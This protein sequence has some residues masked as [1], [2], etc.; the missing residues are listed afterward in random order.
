MTE[1]VRS[2]RARNILLAA[3]LAGLSGGAGLTRAQTAAPVGHN[4][5]PPVG[6]VPAPPNGPVA[7][8]PNAPVAAPPNAPVAAPPAAASISSAPA[9]HAGREATSRSGDVEQDLAALSRQAADAITVCRDETLRC[10]ADALDR[11][12][13]ALRDVAPRLPPALRS[14][15]TIVADAAR[16]V[17]AARTVAEAAQAVK[18]AI[19]RVRKTIALLKADD[20]V[21]LRAETREGS[22]VADTLEAASDKLEKAVGL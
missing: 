8:P 4:P 16:R 13:Q 20:P 9:A 6:H 22:L 2:G 10:V 5:A 1:W 11:Y 15:P 7:A 21:I 12:A 17:R 19:G 14:L 3:A 18:T